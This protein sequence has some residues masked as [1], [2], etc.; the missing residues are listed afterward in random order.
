MAI[1]KLN[2]LVKTPH[3]V[4]NKILYIKNKLRLTQ[5]P[6]VLILVQE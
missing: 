4:L 5:V 1:K 3:T 2:Y 6:L